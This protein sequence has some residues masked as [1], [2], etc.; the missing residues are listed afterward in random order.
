MASLDKTLFKLWI[1]QPSV[2]TIEEVF[3]AT[4]MAL[5]QLNAGKRMNTGGN[6]EVQYDSSDFWTGLNQKALFVRAYMLI[7][8]NYK[9][10]ALPTWAHMVNEVEEIPQGSFGDIFKIVN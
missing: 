3:M 9:T 10:S 5:E 1:D 7:D 2:N 8:P 4:F 6:L